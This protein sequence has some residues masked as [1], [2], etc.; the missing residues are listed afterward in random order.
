MVIE[1][2]PEAG[3][4][5]SPLAV[6][7][8]SRATQYANSTSGWYGGAEVIALP[9]SQSAEAGQMD[10]IRINQ[11]AAERLR[12]AHEKDRK[13]EVSPQKEQEQEERGGHFRFALLLLRF[14]FLLLLLLLLLLASSFFFLYG[15]SS[16]ISSSMSIKALAHPCKYT[17]ELC[18]TKNQKPSRK[19]PPPLITTITSVTDVMVIISSSPSWD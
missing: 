9:I 10:A 3:S 5:G 16:T 1:H 4:H 14:L 13:K 7:R 18:L 6:N 17:K 2:E 8:R 12:T 11:A 19:S 15:R